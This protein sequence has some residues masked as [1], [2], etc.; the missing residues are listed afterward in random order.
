MV[1]RSA[2][3]ATGMVISTYSLSQ[4]SGTLIL[5]SFWE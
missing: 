2:S 1:S 5:V 4:L 3:S